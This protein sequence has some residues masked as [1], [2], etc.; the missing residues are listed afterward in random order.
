MYLVTWTKNIKEMCHT[1]VIPCIFKVLRETLHCKLPVEVA[2]QGSHEMDDAMLAALQ[3]QFGPLSGFDVA[4][5]PY[6]KHIRRCG[7]LADQ[8]AGLR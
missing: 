1:A 5:K 2:W 8:A 7:L 4:A 6:P 3:K